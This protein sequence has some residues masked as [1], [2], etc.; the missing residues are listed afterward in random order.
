M[1]ADEFGDR[2]LHDLERNVD[3]GRDDV[4]IFDLGLGERGLFDGAPHHR[5]GSAVHLAGGGELEQLGDDRG[6]AGVVHREVRVVPVAE[7]AQPLELGAL[8]RDPFGGVVAAFGA[9]LG[10][11][12]VVLVELALAV[13]FL[14]LP[15]NRQAV[16]VPAGHVG[17]V[18]A[19]QRLRADDDVLED[20]VHRVAHVDVAVCVGRAVV[21]DEARRACAGGADLVVEAGLLPFREDLGF[22][23]REAGFH[24][25]V[26]AG[27]E[28]GVFVVGHVVED[29][30][31]A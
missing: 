20:L 10:A 9:E 3:L 17:R 25:E 28:D 31:E 11:G 1:R 27:E 7:H 18:L 29:L 5:L 24:G 2:A 6:L 16:A 15:F 23:A 30:A 12:D 14:D 8:D 22:L 26:G 4:L 19:E 13:R 21:E